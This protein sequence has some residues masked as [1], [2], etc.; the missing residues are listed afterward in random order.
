MIKKILDQYRRYRDS[1]DEIKYLNNKIIKLNETIE[2]NR[3]DYEQL[4]TNIKYLK[5]KRAEQD[6]EKLKTLE[7]DISVN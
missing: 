7:I 1:V 4:Q 6:F 3:L 5:L 2:R